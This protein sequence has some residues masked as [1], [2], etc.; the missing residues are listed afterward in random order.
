MT[1]PEFTNTMIN[2]AAL[3]VQADWVH[4]VLSAPLQFDNGTVELAAEYWVFS[5]SLSPAYTGTE[6][7]GYFV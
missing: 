6:V 3:D 2:A 7:L 1:G 4:T 5:A